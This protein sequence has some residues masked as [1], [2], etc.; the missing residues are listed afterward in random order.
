VVAPRRA[1][2]WPG[3]VYHISVVHCCCPQVFPKL[4]AP[5]GENVGYSECARYNLAVKPRKGD[6]LLFHRSVA[7]CVPVC[8]RAPL[9]HLASLRRASC[10]P[11]ALLTALHGAARAQQQRSSA[12]GSWCTDQALLTHLVLSCRASCFHIEA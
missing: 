7:A 5:G 2:V 1:L 8:V 4:P 3:T 10:L 12:H 11:G 9:L 6:A